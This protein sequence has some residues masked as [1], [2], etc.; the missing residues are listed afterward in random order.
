MNKIIGSI[1]VV[2]MLVNTPLSAFE[3]SAPPLERDAPNP[4]TRN[5]EM[6][7]NYEDKM[8]NKGKRGIWLQDAPP[9][10]RD[11]PNLAAPMVPGAAV[12]QSDEGKRIVHPQY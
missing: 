8:R 5:P 9:M 4:V 6:K 11:A 1:F 10:E 7:P 3:N 2:L 12:S